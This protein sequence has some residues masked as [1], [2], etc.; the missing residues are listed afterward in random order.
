MNGAD[1]N[2]RVEDRTKTGPVD[3]DVA[4]RKCNEQKDRTLV[5]IVLAVRTNLLYL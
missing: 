2:G 1:E 4:M 5:S 3:D